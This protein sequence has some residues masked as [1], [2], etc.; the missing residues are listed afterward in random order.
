MPTQD[1]RGRGSAWASSG[2]VSC[3]ACRRGDVRS[4]ASWL[5]SRAWPPRHVTARPRVR[6]A[7]ARQQ[8]GA[9]PAWGTARSR[10]GD[11]AA[12]RAT[13]SSLGS[14]ARH[15][16]GAAGGTMN[17]F[18]ILGDLSHLLAMILLLV[19]IWRSK[20]CAGERRPGRGGTGP[21]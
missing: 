19:K 14:S 20:S 15:G 9:A 6:A 1:Q 7:G 3:P 10:D 8:G 2:C 16:A 21:W 4:A 11:V 13:E 18:R 5:L 17:V 12:P